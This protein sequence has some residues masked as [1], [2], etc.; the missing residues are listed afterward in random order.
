MS[1]TVG[2]VVSI[3]M[4]DHDKGWVQEKAEVVNPYYPPAFGPSF[5]GRMLTG[6]HEGTVLALQVRHV[7]GMEVES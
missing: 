2:Q 3:K 5:T 7:K 6:R 4:F 1:L